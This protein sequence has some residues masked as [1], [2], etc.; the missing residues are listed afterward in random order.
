[1]SGLGTMMTGGKPVGRERSAADFYPTPPAA[2][3]P[4]VQAV[5]PAIRAISGGR[6]WEPACGDGALA[7]TLHAAGLE[8]TAT[9]LHSYGYDGQFQTVDFLR[10]RRALA[11][12]VVTNPPFNLATEFIEHAL[13]RLRVEGLGLLLKAT[14][15]HAGSR[16]G[17]WRRFPPRAIYPLAWRVDFTGEGA[18]TMDLTWFWWGPGATGHCEVR[19]LERPDRLPESLAAAWRPPAAMRDP[20]REL[21]GSLGL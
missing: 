14:F 10:T 19:P 11:P 12:V 4:F 8:V 21:Q 6:V 5:D 3:W 7:E 18:S 15:W 13:G 20:A 1:M 9:D 17:L 16:V 2:S